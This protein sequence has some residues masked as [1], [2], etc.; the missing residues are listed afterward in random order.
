SARK[1]AHKNVLYEV[2]SEETV[3]WLRS[4]EGQC[5]FA[6]KFGTEISLASRPFSMLIEYIPIALEVENPNVHR[7]IE[8]R[9]NL[10]AGS[11]CSARWIK[12][13]ER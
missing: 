9:N 13:I 10:S 12:P 1:T 2:D 5:L 4:P 11:I 8:R 6:S 3:A 7:D